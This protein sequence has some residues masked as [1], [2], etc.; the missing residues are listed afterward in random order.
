ML[1]HDQLVLHGI[2]SLTERTNLAPL[3]CDIAPHF[4]FEENETTRELSPQIR[5]EMLAALIK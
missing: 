5:G 1:S 2:E 3:I 4:H